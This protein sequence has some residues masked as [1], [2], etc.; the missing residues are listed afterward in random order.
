MAVRNVPMLSKVHLESMSSTGGFHQSS[1]LG[2]KNLAYFIAKVIPYTEERLI[3]CGCLKTL[4]SSLSGM[5]PSALAKKK[6]STNSSKIFYLDKLPP[7]PFEPMSWFRKTPGGESIQEKISGMHHILN[8]DPFIS[9]NWIEDCSIEQQNPF[10]NPIAA[11]LESALISYFEG[12]KR[13]PPAS[14]SGGG[15]G[16]GDSQGIS[17][18]D[19][20]RVITID[21]ESEG[22]CSIHNVSTKEEVEAST[23][24]SYEHAAVATTIKSAGNRQL[25]VH[26]P[27][28]IELISPQQKFGYFGFKCPKG[29]ELKEAR[30]R[31]SV[32]IVRFLL[33]KYIKR[34]ELRQEW[35]DDVYDQESKQDDMADAFLQLY[36][37]VLIARKLM[38]SWSVILEINRYVCSQPFFQTKKNKG[39]IQFN[40][41]ALELKQRF[42]K[43]EQAKITASLTN[44]TVANDAIV[45]SVISDDENNDQNQESDEEDLRDFVPS[46]KR[47][48][49]MKKKQHKEGHI[50][51]NEKKNK[52]KKKKEE[53]KR[54]DFDEESAADA[55]GR[56]DDDD[57]GSSPFMIGGG[58]FSSTS[59]SRSFKTKKKKKSSGNNKQNNWFAKQ[60]RYNS[61]YTAFH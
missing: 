16:G 14:N 20:Q 39:V 33:L 2:H 12:R 25:S 41:K 29:D 42:I 56:S 27:R 31:L 24:S 60:G 37:K 3:L 53:Y 9:G 30:K 40:K 58:S 36:A 28:T 51:K 38:L 8:E 11:Q 44:M 34:G 32:L 17:P 4:V 49:D 26:W 21:L 48:A 55:S 43:A 10:K 50:Q 5:S 22:I 52:K 19:V 18:V 46:K 15:G 13:E 7:I 1:D 61:K 6:S 54:D 45:L 57:G 47:K 59:T 23:L 35:L